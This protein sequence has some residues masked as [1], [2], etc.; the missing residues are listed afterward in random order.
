MHAQTSIVSI[1]QAAALL[2]IMPNKIRSIADELEIQP[3]MQINMVPH[4]AESDLERI[5]ENFRQQ[6]LAGN[7][8]QHLADGIH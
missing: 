4:Y 2:Q 7:E 3:A 5:A 8:L 6:S 1:G